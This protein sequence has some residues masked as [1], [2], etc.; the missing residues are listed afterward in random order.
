MNLK[1]SK[2]LLSRAV[3][4]IFY[5]DASGRIFPAG[6]KND[7]RWWGNI[8][9]NELHSCLP[10]G[11]AKLFT[12][13]FN[14]G[15]RCSLNCPHCFV[16]E[17][18]G[19]SLTQEELLG[20][21]EEG[22]K[23]GLREAKWLGEGD[24]FEYPMAVEFIEKANALGV[25][26]SIF[27]KGHTLGSDELAIRYYGMTAQELVQRLKKLNV[28][29]LLGFNSFDRAQQERW[30]GVDNYPDTALLKNYVQFRD[31]ALINLVRAG[32]NEY[33]PGQATRLAF[34]CA[35]FKPENIDE[36]LR[37]LSGQG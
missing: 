1:N 20:Y 26:I 19:V 33:I 8:P 10:D 30:V 12:L 4:A 23:L 36:V 13:D 11:T 2:E 9:E 14:L 27:T 5:P 32:F 17:L 29:I 3:P 37:C 15:K 7:V 28:S 16:P 18:Q 31:Q 24:P 22:T 21:F 35:P 6:Y 25:G 34:S